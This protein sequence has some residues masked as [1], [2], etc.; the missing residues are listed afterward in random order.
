MGHRAFK[1]FLHGH[2]TSKW[3]SQEFTLGYLPTPPGQTQD[4]SPAPSVNLQCGVSC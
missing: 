1:D 4:L 2:T 3:Q